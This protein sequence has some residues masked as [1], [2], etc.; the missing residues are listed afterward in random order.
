MWMWSKPFSGRFCFTRSLPLWAWASSSVNST[1]PTSKVV[2]IVCCNRSSPIHL[3]VLCSNASF[4]HSLVHSRPFLLLLHSFFSP[5]IC[6]RI[7]RWN[8]P[9][10]VADAHFAFDR[11]ACWAC[12][13]R[14]YPD[15]CTDSV[16]VVYGA[17]SLIPCTIWLFVCKPFGFLEVGVDIWDFA[18]FQLIVT[19]KYS[20]LTGRESG[21]LSYG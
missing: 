16:S 21:I 4:H 6:V 2:F 8:V 10:C 12:S 15:W 11:I 13:G 7:Q 18:E 20:Y 17:F 9:S 14:F 1:S 3:L 5:G 19:G